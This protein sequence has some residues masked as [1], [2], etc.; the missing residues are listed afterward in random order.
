MPT[1]LDHV[2]VGLITVI[3]PLHDL[4]FWYPRMVR[5]A[6]GDAGRARHEAYFES[7]GVEWVVVAATL[8]YWSRV[9]RSWGALG[10]SP[11][12]GWGFW[13]GLGVALGFAIFATWERLSLGRQRDSEVR[14]VVLRQLD[15]LRPILPHSRREMLHFSAV[16]LTAGI[17]EEVLYRGF[18][19][20]YL[21]LLVPLPVAVGVAAL[22]FG[23][24]HAY[25]GARGVIQTGLVGLGLAVL[26]VLSGSLWLPMALHAFVDLN[27][28]LLAYS[29]LRREEEMSWL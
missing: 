10:F 9:D 18:L 29:F 26:Y 11:P 25:Q 5:A 21:A 8:V 13:I 6:A 4:L 23:M 20:W 28:G 2:V 17:C 7:M 22:L 3:L 15:N 24:A 27:S 12:S 19:I 14:S 1:P 16:A